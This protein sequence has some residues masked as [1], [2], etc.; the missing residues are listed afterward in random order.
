[1]FERNTFRSKSEI[2]SVFPAFLTSCIPYFLLFVACA[3]TASAAEWQAGFS[4]VDAT[5]TEALRLSGYG[6]RSKPSEGVDHKLWVRTMVLQADGKNHALVSVDSIGFPGSLVTLIA[7]RLQKDHGIPRERFVLCTTHSHT[8][9]ALAHGLTNIF[10]VPFTPEETAKT[11]AYTDSLAEKVVQSVAVAIKDLQ[12]AQVFRGEGKAAFAANRRVLTNGKWTGFGVTAGAPVD[13]SLPLLKIT[14]AAGKLR[15]VVYN[16][17][18][19]ATTLGPDHNRV[20]GDWPGISATYLEE[21]NLGTVFLSIIGCGADANPEPRGKLEMAEA[22]GRAAAVAVQQALAGPLQKIT[23]APVA[24]FGHA[25]LHV[26]RPSLDDLR[27]N[28]T[29]K[30]P[31]TARHAA[32]MLDIYQKMGRL[33]ETFPMPV[34]AWRFGNEL[35]M[36]FL[37]EETVVD[38]ALRLKKEIKSGY[39]WVTAY[40]ND[41]SSYVASERIRREGGY[42]VTGSMIYY[43]QPGPWAEGTEEV[44]IRR[45]HEILKN[46]RT[47][48]ALA[49]AEALK[50]FQLAEGFEIEL[51]AAE[52]LITDPVNFAFG[53]DGKLWVAEMGDYPRGIGETGAPGGKIC[54][55]EDKD[56]DGKY[57]KSTVFLDGLSYPTGVMP[58][59]KGVLVSCAP[60]IFYAED[61][62]GDGRADIRRVLFTGFTEANPQHR[63]NGFAYGLDNWV[64]LAS[65]ATTGKVMSFIAGQDMNT[66]GGDIRIQPETGLLEPAGGK[67]QCGRHRDDW[68]HWFGGNNSRPLQQFVLS[69]SYLRRNPH[70]PAANTTTDVLTP[71]VAPAVYP[72]SRTVDRFNDLF[73]ANRFT[74]ACSPMVFRDI[75]LG[76][77]VEGAAFVCEPVHNLVHRSRLVLDGVTFRGERQPTEQ[78]SEFLSS[79]D[80]WSRPVHL[81]TGPDGALWVADMYRHVIEH[82]QWIPQDWQK[83]LD[84]R[85]G[86]DKGRIYRVYRKG[87][88]PS[89][90]PNLAG[91]STAELIGRLESTNGTVRDLA[92]QLLVERNDAAAVDLLQR[93]LV[94][95]ASAK[96]R[97][98]ALYTLDGMKALTADHVSRGLLDRDWH[99]QLHAARL[100]EPLLG[101]NPKLGERLLSLAER[102]EPELRLQVALSLGEWNDPRAGD[103]LAK[104]AVR[105]VESPWMRAAVLSSSTNSAEKILP[106]VLAEAKQS[107]GRGELVD[108]LIATLLGSGDVGTQRVL[109]ILAGQSAEKNVAPWQ[110]AALVGFV[111]ALERRGS[112][113]AK[114]QSGSG[115]GGKS[116]VDKLQSIFNAARDRALDVNAPLEDRE[117]ALRLLARGLDRRDE[118]LKALTQFLGPQTPPRLQ[119]AAVATLARTRASDVPSLLLAGWRGYS[120]DLQG[121]VLDTLLTR[122]EWTAALLTAIEAKTIA[123]GDLDAAARS[124]LLNHRTSEIRERSIKALAASVNESRAKVLADHQPVLAMPGNLIRGAAV[125]NRTCANC[126]RVR[127]RGNELGPNLAPF[128][129]KPAEA[130]LVAMLD[131]SQA[132]ERRYRNYVAATKD[133]RVFSGLI[134]E[135]SSAS[136]TLVSQNAKRETILR[137]D[138]DELTGTDKSFMPEG[139]E[140]DLSPQDM[141]DVIA[142]VRSRIDAKPQ[143]AEGRRLLTEAGANGIAEVVFSS[144]KKKVSNW[145]GEIETPYCTSGNGTSRVTWRTAPLTSSSDRTKPQLFRL[146]VAMSTGNNL[147]GKF[148]LRWNGGPSVDF[149]PV[150]TDA[151][152]SSTEGGAVMRYLVMATERD[153]SSGVLEIELPGDAVSLSG[154]AFTIISQNSAGRSWVALLPVTGQ[155]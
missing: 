14:D 101:K 148:Q 111:D 84:L 105:D 56:G 62:D 140:K 45:V 64:Y 80:V 100:S 51:V 86:E 63:V 124:R 59:K 118:D 129:D 123:A 131:P 119:T 44:L 23:A 27:K 29:H 57:D 40:A 9:P 19:H 135:E 88:R 109:A 107:P 13:H 103:A 76:P 117:T 39:V 69:D 10:A 22:H 108:R 78:K 18:C 96:A 21:Q 93:T 36:I 30:T 87:L 25:G 83:R 138:V 20:N 12:P 141:A 7:N 90:I 79:T 155:N 41:V 104:L 85:A 133:G 150:I 139:L 68:G 61:A 151:V 106:V 11:Q 143:A 54:F 132:V 91:Q 74:S 110:I 128:I 8:T 144:G 99:V 32:N 6:N 77:G 75:T 15:G 46:E 35:T 33:P 16:Y 3:T 52:P 49:P 136:L 137:A 130:A 73:A 102:P 17:A 113:V 120:P 114:L 70:V 31:Q 115:A 4:K 125:F 146:A 81:A 97:M 92:Q 24:S 37:G 60:D 154:V 34:Q 153:E 145:L 82:P 116:F 95:S 71:A 58:W 2:L 66:A 152:W 38:Y 134:V 121:T 127:G 28:L 149:M 55:L 126:H 65:E 122:A 89:P 48:G 112:S 94:S 98:H 26:E 147:P 72:S 1:M 47:E 53:P 50:S 67:T 142:F 42:E 43:N 5:P